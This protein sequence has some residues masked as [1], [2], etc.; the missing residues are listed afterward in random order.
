MAEEIRDTLNAAPTSGE[1]SG[2]N[3]AESLRPRFI[4]LGGVELPSVSREPIGRPIDL[5]E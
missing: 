4:A 5:D 3:L 1:E 2:P